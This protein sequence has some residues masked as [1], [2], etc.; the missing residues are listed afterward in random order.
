MGTTVT[1]SPLAPFADAFYTRMAGD[2][3]LATL[4]PGG[5]FA[6]LPESRRVD[7]ANGAYIVVGHRTL[8][9]RAGAMQREGGNADV[10]V[11]VWS[12]YNGPAET[13]DIQAQIRRLFQ[14]VDLVVPGFALYS[15]SVTCAEE[16]C[17][18]DWDPDMPERS[19]F[20][21][22]QRWTGLLEEVN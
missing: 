4:A 19:L 2:A 21:G 7:P 12:A 10:L 16:M 5:V 9:T 8:G 1:G 6:S 11:D 22:V 17:F 15:G 18:P 3:R 14:R 20:H 13:Q